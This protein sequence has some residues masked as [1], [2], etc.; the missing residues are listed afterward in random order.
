MS[1]NKHREDRYA[2]KQSTTGKYIDG[3]WSPILTIADAAHFSDK[4]EAANFRDMV[5]YRRGLKG[6]TIVQVRITHKEI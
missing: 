1:K 6:L 4:Q 3:D 5:A 2:V